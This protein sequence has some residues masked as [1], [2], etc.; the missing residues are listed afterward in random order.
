[1]K[2]KA[3]IAII[4]IGCVV[5]FTCHFIAI[6]A[7][8]APHNES[9]NIDCVRAVA[10]AKVSSSQSSG[11]EVDHMTGSVQIYVICLR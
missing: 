8:D 2:I 1:M 5:A 9:N 7:I 4:I 11:A 3:L 6:A 10:T